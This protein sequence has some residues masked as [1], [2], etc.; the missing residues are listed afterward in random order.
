MMIQFDEHIFQMGSYHQLLY[1]KS[2]LINLQG[3]LGDCK[4][5]IGISHRGPMLGIGVPP[6]PHWNSP[7]EIRSFHCALEPEPSALEAA[8]SFGQKL[9]W[10]PWDHTGGGWGQGQGWI[11]KLIQKGLVHTPRLRHPNTSWQGVGGPSTFSGGVWMPRVPSST[12]NNSTI[13]RMSLDWEV[14][15]FATCTCFQSE[16]SNYMPD[17]LRYPRCWLISGYLGA[18]S[19]TFITRRYGK[20]RKCGST[21][22]R[23]P[24][25]RNEIYL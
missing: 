4:A 20:F 23:S 25:E 8:G 1:S 19:T 18:W 22:D 10:P 11:N 24:F 13:L 9:Q 15:F 16:M 3:I 12:M 21:T 5:Y 6:A 17:P 14:C 2:G 7:V